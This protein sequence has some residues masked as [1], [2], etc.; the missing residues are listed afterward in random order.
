LDTNPNATPERRARSI[1]EAAKIL[2]ISRGGAY[3]AAKRGELP[4]LKIG[5]RLV[6]PDAAL[7][8]LLGGNA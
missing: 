8:R 2:G 6:V 4:V 1:D 3:L 5:K 7:E